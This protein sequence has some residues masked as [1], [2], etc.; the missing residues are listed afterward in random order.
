VLVL[1][2][3]EVEVVEHSPQLHQ[4]VLVVPV[5][6]SLLILHKYSKNTKWA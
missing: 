6:S 2:A 1:K 5:L 3:L 4:L